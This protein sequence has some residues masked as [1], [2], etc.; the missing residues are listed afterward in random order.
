M[1]KP[2]IPARMFDDWP[3]IPVD[4]SRDSVFTRVERIAQGAAAGRVLGPE[5]PYK[6]PD[7]SLAEIVHG[8]VREGLLHLAELGLIDIDAERLDAAHG[9]PIHRNTFR[10]TDGPPQHIG[11]GRNAEDCPACDALNLPYPFLC[12]GPTETTNV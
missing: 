3:R 5:G 4:T 2:P 1:T 7:Q 9:Y 10:P 6:R 11:A 12:P 8:A